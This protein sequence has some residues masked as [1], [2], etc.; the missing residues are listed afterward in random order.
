MEYRIRIKVGKEQA[1]LQIIRALQS[2]GVVEIAERVVTPEQNSKPES[3]LKA[4]EV[5]SQYRDLVD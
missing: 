5:A 1:F 4:D 2:L 3:R